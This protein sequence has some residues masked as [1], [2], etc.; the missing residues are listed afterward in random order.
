VEIRE[1]SKRARERGKS[2]RGRRVQAIPLIMGQPTWLL[3]GNCGRGV[4]TE[5][6][7]LEALP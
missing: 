5:Y 6:Q 4:Q 3:P 7:G 2:K 1:G